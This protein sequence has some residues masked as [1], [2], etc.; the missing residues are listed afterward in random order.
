LIK[1]GSSGGVGDALLV[2]SKMLNKYP[3]KNIFWQHYTGHQIHVEPI[4]DIINWS[5][6]SN[7]NGRCFQTK[8][9]AESAKEFG[10]Y[11][12][13]NI[14][15]SDAQLPK[16]ETNK[17][18]ACI[19][20]NAGRS[21][22]NTNRTVC[23]DLID[24][25]ESVDNIHLLGTHVRCTKTESIINALEIID[26]CK[27]FI[28]QDGALAYYSAMIG[29]PTLINYHLTSLINHY[30][31]QHWSKNVVCTFQGN[32]VVVIPKQFAEI[33]TPL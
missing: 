18:Y 15:N 4:N 31:T 9:T 24:V 10:E 17:N 27:Y 32:N 2:M 21:N 6:Y 26:Y 23:D 20:Y 19:A 13:T 1:I 25:I 22:D 3:D 28:G 30:Y 33:I 7:I 11:I 14:I 16:Q 29:K 8:K 5:R 12:D